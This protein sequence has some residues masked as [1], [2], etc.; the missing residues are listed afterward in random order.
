MANEFP[1]TNFFPDQPGSDPRLL[2]GQGVADPFSEAMN[3]ALRG[4]QVGDRILPGGI[5]ATKEEGS[6][7]TFSATGVGMPTGPVFT[8]GSTA[9]KADIFKPFQDQLNAIAA[10]KDPIKKQQLMIATEASFGTLM[11]EKSKE[12]RTL[13]EQQLGIEEMRKQ[14]V[15]NEKLDRADPKWK[16]FQSDSKMTAQVRQTLTQLESRVDSHA[17]GLLRDNPDIA[18]LA[19]TIDGNF[20]LQ[21]GL[22]Q[23]AELADLNRTGKA[24][25]KQEALNS[26]MS[27]IPPEVRGSF[28][29][30][31]PSL[32]DDTTFAAYIMQAAKSGKDKDSFDALMTGAVTP[33]NY[34]QAGL[35]GNTIAA[36]LAAVEQ[37][38]R[39]GLPKD[40]VEK[41]MQAAAAFVSQPEYF[42]KAATSTGLM[43]SAQAKVYAAKL[44]A[45][46]KEGNKELALQRL[47]LVEPFMSAIQKQT[48]D[49]DI[50]SWPKAEGEPTIDQAPG[51]LPVIE[52]FRATAGR[53]PSIQ[54]FSS[55]YLS[56]PGLTP[57]ETSQRN[58]LVGDAY[59]RALERSKMG[60]FGKSID[61]VGAVNGILVQNALK[62]QGLAYNIGQNIGQVTEGLVD[63]LLA[64][65]RAVGS[66]LSSA[67]KT[68][69][70]TYAGILGE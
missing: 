22:I 1:I 19:K 53:N 17:Q 33:E 37:A 31:N 24:E 13:A 25:Q 49:K 27:S 40:V 20:A 54:E 18:R 15:N 3:E 67:G 69:R 51:A 9:S 38:S 23:K 70:E 32:Q 44:A 6:P 7:I 58:Q 63:P 59:A 60:I 65:G 5:K 2:S 41:N 55:A 14:L 42:L 11:A 30:M 10:E 29:K 56:Q 52:K 16:D 34:L 36:R 35:T 26:L 48:I 50:L 28:V 64:P 62:K 61:T 57:Q 68:L 8:A 47:A 4:F 45:G 12:A 66:G 21:R 43:T 46:D 39:T